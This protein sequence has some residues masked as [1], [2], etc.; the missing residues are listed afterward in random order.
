MTMPAMKSVKSSNVMAVGYDADLY[1]LYVQ[2]KN[3]KTYEYGLV[4]Q[5]IYE[6]LMKAESI[7]SFVQRHLVRSE[8]H[9]CKMVVDEGGK[10]HG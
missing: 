5:P 7:G 2:F 3:G 9:P 8:N 10:K 1:K 4:S 6:N